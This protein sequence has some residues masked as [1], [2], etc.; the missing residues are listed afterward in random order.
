MVTFGEMVPGH[1][2]DM[3]WL[4]TA[5]M[6]EGTKRVAD[7]QINNILSIKAAVQRG[8]GVAMLPDYVVDKDSGTGPAHAGSRGAR[9]ST[10]ISAI[11]RR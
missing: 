8:A 9:P 3:N 11:R 1:L 7:L 5:G 10:P 6:P 2:S 4:E